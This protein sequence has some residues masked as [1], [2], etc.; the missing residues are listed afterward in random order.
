MQILGSS[1]AFK[2]IK[3]IIVNFLYAFLQQ[4]IKFS[5]SWDMFGKILV[6]VFK[7]MMF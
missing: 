6:F 5:M 2:L 1:H 4:F 7:L 3:N